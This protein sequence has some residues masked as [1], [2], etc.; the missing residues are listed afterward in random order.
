MVAGA[1]AAYTLRKMHRSRTGEE[2]PALRVMGAASAV[3]SMFSECFYCYAFNNTNG[4][5]FIVLNA[6]ICMPAL[7]VRSRLVWVV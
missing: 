6:L 1:C 7:A 2:P 3:S 5:L 4:W